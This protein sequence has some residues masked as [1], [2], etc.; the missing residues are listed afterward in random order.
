MA[1][2]CKACMLPLCTSARRLC[3]ELASASRSAAG[4]C[5]CVVHAAPSAACAQVKHKITQA[6]MAVTFRNLCD[7]FRLSRPSLDRIGIQKIADMRPWRNCKNSSNI[8]ADCLVFQIEIGKLVVDVPVEHNHIIIR[9]RC[10]PDC[11]TQ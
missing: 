3:A 7:I 8:D 1:P 9:S 6:A 10:L 11:G 5:A 4:I 2:C